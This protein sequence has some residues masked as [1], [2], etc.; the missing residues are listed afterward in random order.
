MSGP[1]VRSEIESSPTPDAR[2]CPAVIEV[3]WDVSG[4]YFEAC[5]CD[6]I[7][8]CRVVGD[9]PGGRSTYGICQF[10]LSWQIRTGVADLV[11]LDDLAVVMAGWY[12][13][14]APGS[15]WSVTLYVDDRGDAGQ[16]DALA[17]IF[18]GRAGGG[19]L[20]NFAAAI[21]TVHAVRPA[22]IELSHA[23]RRWSM[24]ASTYLTVTAT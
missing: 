13:D 16:Q 8:P 17:A 15:P 12:D 18:L 20:H 2:Q 7:C 22:T 14:D 21:A 10:A 3:E 6:A 5:N 19:T 9:K 11:C 24:R 1:P 4:T 23:P